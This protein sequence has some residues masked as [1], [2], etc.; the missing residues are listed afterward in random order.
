MGY[1]VT[2]GFCAHCVGTPTITKKVF[3]RDPEGYEI[4]KKKVMVADPLFGIVAELI[5]LS[6]SVAVPAKYGTYGLY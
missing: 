6:F 3:I 4:I 2:L 1:L 5:Y